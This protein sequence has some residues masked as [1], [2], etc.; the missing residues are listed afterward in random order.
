MDEEKPPRS[1]VA[2]WE[3]W[4]SFSL[5]VPVALM[6]S[7]SR[8]WLQEHAVM[9]FSGAIGFVLGIGAFRFGSLLTRTCAAIL[10]CIHAWFL[11]EAIRVLAP[12][13]FE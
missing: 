1:R 7:T 6:P 12:I 13:A 8:Y 2:F 4:I 11:Y 9:G 3:A 10:I 5:V